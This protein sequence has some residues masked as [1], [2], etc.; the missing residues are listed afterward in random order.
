MLYRIG[1]LY[2]R[3]GD[4]RS[5]RRAYL[6]LVARDPHYRDAYAKL[7][8]Q[9]D[10]TVVEEGD[11]SGERAFAE[12]VETEASREVKTLFETLGTLDL[13]LDPALLAEARAA[14]TASTGSSDDLRDVDFD[15]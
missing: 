4:R 5:A 9:E 15:F 11:A 3:G 14:A 7:E 12:F 2:E 10:A 8:S 1:A 6:E 13:A